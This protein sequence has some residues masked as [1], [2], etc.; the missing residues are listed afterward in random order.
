MLRRSVAVPA[1]QHASSSAALAVVSVAAFFLPA[2]S[3]GGKQNGLNGQIKLAANH[4]LFGMVARP[5]FGHFPTVAADVE[6]VDGRFFMKDTGRYELRLAS[7]T[8]LSESEY[9]LDP[10]GKFSIA[11][12]TSTQTV[13]YGGAYGLEGQSG[14]IV[15]TD[16]LGSGIGL[17][18]GTAL[19]QGNPDLP[20]MVGNWHVFTLHAV[21]APAGSVPDED[22]VGLA[23]GGTI[24]LAADGSFTG[25]GV[26][27]ENGN[28]SVRGDPNDF[29]AFADGRF[30]LEMLYDPPTRP[31]YQRGFVAGGTTRFVAGVDEDSGGTDGAAGTVLL[32]RH[33]T[34]AY[35]AAD[36]AGKYRLGMQTLFIRSD[37]SGSD[38]ALGE[39]ELTATGDFRID[40]T[41]NQGVDFSYTGTFVAAADGTLTFTV[42]GTTE[43]WRGA[44]DDGYDTVVF[45][46]P[47]KEVRA[48][49]QKELNLGV[50]LRPKPVP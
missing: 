30:A 34:A 11:V 39:L 15:L 6:T 46:D 42:T 23:F 16:R 28:I 12:P 37:A 36:L 50:A 13:V 18:V 35:A 21:L 26:E 31:D 25:T 19:V 24:A 49:L 41:N 22:S 17:Y 32:M 3:S 43:T 7:G 38:S 48:N 8:L 14:D 4:Y 5:S 45:V 20:A 27:S 33:R 9:A 1:L 44:F 40:A 2:C 47:F 10:D 29:Q